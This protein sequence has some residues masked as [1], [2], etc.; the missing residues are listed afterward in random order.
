[1]E[2]HDFACLL[3]S[4]VVFEWSFVLTVNEKTFLNSS[5]VKDF[6]DLKIICLLNGP[7]CHIL[8]KNLPLPLLLISLEYPVEVIF[9]N[10]AS[11][12]SEIVTFSHRLIVSIKSSIKLFINNRWW[13]CLLKWLHG[14]RCVIERLR[15]LCSLRLL[16]RLMIHVFIVFVKFC[17]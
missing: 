10:Y 11:V 12:L 13:G 8:A 6:K 2:Y 4:F 5:Y 9:F 1:M 16:N 7:F 17:M 15:P 3:S 14:V